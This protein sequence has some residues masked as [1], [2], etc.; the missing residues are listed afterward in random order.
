MRYAL[1][2]ATLALPAAAQASSICYYNNRQRV[3]QTQYARCL[4]LHQ[5]KFSD[6]AVFSFSCGVRNTFNLFGALCNNPC[7]SALKGLRNYAAHGKTVVYGPPN[8]QTS[9][10]QNF[11]FALYEGSCEQLART[12][13]EGGKAA[14]ENI[15]DDALI[16]AAE[17]PPP[18]RR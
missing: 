15:V 1:L 2:F 5:A 4:D 16:K 7:A 11:S 17:L 9:A 8:L 3:V 12:V 6:S 14:L 10:S 13:R 18:A